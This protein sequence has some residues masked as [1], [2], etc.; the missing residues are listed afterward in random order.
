MFYKFSKSG[1]DTKTKACFYN[2]GS[3]PAYSFYSD[4][5]TKIKNALFEK[6]V[7]RMLPPIL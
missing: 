6:G 7:L 2:H 3:Q 5:H 1:M 4:Q